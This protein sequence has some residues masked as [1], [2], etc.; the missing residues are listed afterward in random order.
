MN[1]VR[2]SQEYPRAGLQWAAGKFLVS[3]SPFPTNNYLATVLFSNFELFEVC[4]KSS[5]IEPNYIPKFQSC[6]G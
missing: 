4:L 1:T 5:T 2:Y 6:L 3:G